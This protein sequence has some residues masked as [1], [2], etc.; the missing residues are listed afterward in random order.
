MGKADYCPCRTFAAPEN[1]TTGEGRWVVISV[2]SE[3]NHP[4]EIGLPAWRPP[5]RTRVREPHKNGD[6]SGT[7]GKGKEKKKR[8]V[9]NGTAAPIVGG[10]EAS[11]GEIDGYNERDLERSTVGSNASI[12]GSVITS[13]TSSITGPRRR[14]MDDSL[15]D[16]PF[17]QRSPRSGASSSSSAFQHLP[18]PSHFSPHGRHASLPPFRAVSPNPISISSTPVPGSNPHSNPTS[19]AGTPF[20]SF[21]Q[22]PAGP[23]PVPLFEEIIQSLSPMLV[24]YAPVLY[25]GGLNTS[26]GLNRFWLLPEVDLVEFL[27][28]VHVEALAYGM[29]GEG[30]G[31]PVIQRRVLL[32]RVLKGRA[33][34]RNA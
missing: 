2:V 6:E 30:E 28:R 1:L 13:T 12:S 17:D 19:A 23:I 4:K 27:M 8:K 7:R 20:S 10:N 14:S 24:D 33:S 29:G 26:E 11:D 25:R 22:L 3:H 16:H 18:L 15:S 31:L 9:A 32:T 34:D 21:S 5:K